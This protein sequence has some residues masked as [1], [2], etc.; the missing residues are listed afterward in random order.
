MRDRWVDKQHV[1]IAQKTN[2]GSESRFILF[3]ERNKNPKS[4]FTYQ[5]ASGSWALPCVQFTS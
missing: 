3:E 1:E 4:S 2:S 5:P